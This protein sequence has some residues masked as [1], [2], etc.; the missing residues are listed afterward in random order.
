MT[1][2]KKIKLSIIGDS[3]IGKSSILNR[4]IFD[5]FNLNSR[6]TIGVEFGQI[7]IELN[8]G[9]HYLLEIW[10][11]A[12]QCKYRS[13]VKSYYRNVDGFILVFDI[14]NKDSFNNLSYWLNEINGNCDKDDVYI[15]LVGNKIDL[16][17]KEKDEKF[18]FDDGIIKFINDNNNNN[19]NILPKY[20]ITSAKNNV[21][22]SLLFQYLTEE[23]DYI[24]K[25]R[26]NLNNLNLK[27]ENENENENEKKNKNNE[28][29]KLSNNNDNNNNNNKNNKK[30]CL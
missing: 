23:L 5:K 2:L 10:D 16:Y 25:I 18:N 28:K 8:N 20:Y 9:E 3:G 17:D 19:Y 1:D 29:I 4:Y 14:T 15:L 30:C 11:T 21:S 12:G 7:E 13:I 26:N 24:Y 6:S 22:I 27:N